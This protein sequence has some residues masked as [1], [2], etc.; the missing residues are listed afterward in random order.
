MKEKQE[1][2][3]L[4]KK[5]LPATAFNEMRKENESMIS[6]M[7]NQNIKFLLTNRLISATYYS[8]NYGIL[9]TLL[10]D[11]YSVNTCYL[12][13]GM[14]LTFIQNG[15]IRKNQAISLARC[16]GTVNR[17][18]IIAGDFN[19]LPWAAPYRQMHSAGLKDSFHEVGHGSGS[20]YRNLGNFARID[21]IFYNDDL[22]CTDSRI[23]DDLISDHK[24]MVSTFRLVQK[25]AGK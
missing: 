23:V 7:N 13:L 5:F 14:A 21:Y 15:D 20:T 25:E 19:C 1:N 8:M 6:D 3:F 18:L 16:T 17:P 22:V 10:K 2:L 4:M 24:M 9:L 11:V 12:G